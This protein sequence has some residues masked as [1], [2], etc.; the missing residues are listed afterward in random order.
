MPPFTLHPSPVSVH[1]PLIRRNPHPASDDRFQLAVINDAGQALLR[2]YW[3][4]GKLTDLN[5]ALELLQSAVQRTPPNSPDLPMYLSNLSNGL[6][7]RYART[8]DLADLEEAELARLQ[9]EDPARFA[10]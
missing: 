8:G 5:R 2:R 7:G 6:R 1:A 9:A 4:A 10:G 3:S